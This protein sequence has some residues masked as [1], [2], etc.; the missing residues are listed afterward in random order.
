MKTRMAAI[1]ALALLV[2]AAPLAA[3]AQGDLKLETYESPDGLFTI[4]YPA[5]WFS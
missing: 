4:S 1:V 5:G 3:F 2:A